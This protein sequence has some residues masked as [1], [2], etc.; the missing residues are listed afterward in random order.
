MNNA[1]FLDRIFPRERQ[2]DPRQGK[3]IVSPSRSQGAAAF[4]ESDR[5]LL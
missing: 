3:R 1:W 2:L 5:R 4:V